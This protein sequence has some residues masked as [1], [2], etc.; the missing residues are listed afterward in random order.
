LSVKRNLKHKNKKMERTAKRVTSGKRRMT[1]SVRVRRPSL[2]DIVSILQEEKVLLGIRY[3]RV[4]R[5]LDA[6]RSRGFFTRI[7]TWLKELFN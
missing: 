6:Y 3:H 1:R 5:M 2:R 4:K 7:K